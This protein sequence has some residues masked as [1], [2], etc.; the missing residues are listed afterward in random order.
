MTELVS[1][2]SLKID[3]VKCSIL[4]VFSNWL[5]HLY[6]N[7]D[8]GYS[9]TLWYIVIDDDSVSFRMLNIG[10]GLFSASHINGL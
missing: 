8:L 5:V 1:I 9:A 10:I 3:I 6:P 7:V 2:D 4:Y